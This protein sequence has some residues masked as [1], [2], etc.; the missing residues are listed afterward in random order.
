MAVKIIIRIMALVIIITGLNFVYKFTFYKKDLL[1]K[2]EQVILLK[3]KQPETDIFY[4]GESSNFNTRPTD[5]IQNSISEITNFF[6][7]D[8]KIT[9]IIKPATHAGIY[10][11]WMKQIDL[12]KKPKAIIVTLNLRSFDANWIHSRLETQLQEGVVLIKPYPPIINRFLLSLNAFDNKTEQQ[13]EHEM[14]KEWETKKLKFPYDFRY[15][16]VREWDNAMAQG[17]YL[18]PDGSWDN[19]KITLA[20]HYVKTYA[21]NLDDDNP[22]VKDFDFIADWCRKNNINLY[23]NL[24]AE[25]IEYADSL[26][27]KE[28][29]FL[30][31]QNRDYLVN[32]YNKNN[33]KVVDNLELVGGKEFT[34]QSW[35]TEHYGYKGRMIIAK[36]VA[37]ALKSQFNNYYKP[38]Y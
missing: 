7:P 33:C 11:H 25:N 3:E 6:Y 32:R 29:V 9:A 30:M 22:R 4:F 26:V 2:S 27:G 35:T 10:R 1:E 17:S 37:K 38:A 5:S 20:C 16:T 28:L 34:D 21:F 13:R 36:N 23:L 15:K 18:K 19:E 12:S 8:L 31:K 14:L 24:L